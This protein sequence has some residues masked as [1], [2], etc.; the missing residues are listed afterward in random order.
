MGKVFQVAQPTGAKA[1]T[2][3]APWCVWEA[4]DSVMGLHAPSKVE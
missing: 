1:Q 3:E 4:R 2:C